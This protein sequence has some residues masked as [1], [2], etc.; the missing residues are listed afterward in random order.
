MLGTFFVTSAAGTIVLFSIAG[1]SWAFNSRVPYSLL[2]DEIYRE[3]TCENNQDLSS[4]QGLIYGIHNLAICLPQI[5]MISS[6]VIIWGSTE[7]TDSSFGLV[8]FL[9]LGG[10]SSLV[11]AYFTTLLNNLP[12]DRNAVKYIEVPMEEDRY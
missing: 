11:A 7:S 6:M 3:P 10:V 8:W 12:K 4:S 1:V 2:G 5:M 9:R